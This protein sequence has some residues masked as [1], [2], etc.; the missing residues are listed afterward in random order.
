MKL[1]IKI[2]NLF[3]IIKKYSK[4]NHFSKLILTFKN[5]IKKTWEIIKDSISKS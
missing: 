4:I 3:E 2:K 5:N 1:N